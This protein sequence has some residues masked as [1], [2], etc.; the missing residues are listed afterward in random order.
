MISLRR[1]L[2]RL[3]GS[4]Y[5]DEDRR[6]G[7]INSTNRKGEKETFPLMSISLAV[8]VNTNGQFGHPGEISAVAA[9]LKKEIKKVTGVGLCGRPAGSSA[10]IV[11]SFFFLFS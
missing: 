1:I 6:N 11:P 8:V 9:D 5:D 3:R 10:G 2:T 7:F 4:L